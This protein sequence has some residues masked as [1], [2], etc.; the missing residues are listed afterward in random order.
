[1]SCTRDPITND[2]VDRFF[3]VLETMEFYA[4]EQKSR[5][6][7]ASI[8]DLISKESIDL[9]LAHALTKIKRGAY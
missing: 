2:E 8:H 1:M 6:A 3:E 9:I 4:Q 5:L 7:K